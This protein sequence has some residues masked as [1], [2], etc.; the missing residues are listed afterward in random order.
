[1]DVAFVRAV[2]N[3]AQLNNELK[4]ACGARFLGTVLYPGGGTVRLTEG[5]DLAALVQ[6]TADAHDPARKTADQQ[7]V[8]AALAAW[9]NGALAN[10][11]PQEIYTLLQSEIDAWASLADARN[12]LKA[13]L[14]LMG[15]ALWYLMKQEMGE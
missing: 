7:A 12:D 11:T 2:Y 1:M 3:A 8:E 6:A 5:P 4:A 9:R 14:P 15:A 13:W 10:R